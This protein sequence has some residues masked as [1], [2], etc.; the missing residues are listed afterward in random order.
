[1]EKD[2]GLV[3]Q[4]I[5]FKGIMKIIEKMEMVYLHGQVVIFIEVNFLMI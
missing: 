3:K 4:V 5:D 2:F 1:M